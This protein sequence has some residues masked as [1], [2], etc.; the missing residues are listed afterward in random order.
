MAIKTET[1]NAMPDSTFAFPR[2][3]KEPLNDAKH[4]RNAIARFDQVRDVSDKERDE[5]FRRIKKAASR[6]GVELTE[7]SW[8]E[9]GKPDAAR[10]SSDKP[11]PQASRQEL[12]AEARKQNIRG[13]STMT[14]DEL[15]RALR[16]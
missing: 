9:L 8:H 4:V 11:R 2:V 7:K 12:Y 3:R 16:S 13:R 10:R 15:I 5:A 6:Y 1:R 14:K